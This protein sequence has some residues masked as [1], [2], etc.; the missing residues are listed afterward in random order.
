MR[1]EA[2]EDFQPERQDEV[3]E[4][5][6]GAEEWCCH[7]RKAQCPAPLISVKA[8][9]DKAPELVEPYGRTEH[10]AGNS[11]NLHLQHER[12]RDARQGKGHR[13]ALTLSLF[14]DSFE[15]LAQPREQLDVID[16]ADHHADRDCD[17]RLDEP[18]P[19][20]AEMIGERHGHG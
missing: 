4:E 8:R 6:S 2:E 14:D 11:C 15:R 1:G 20:F 19:Q 13:S 3:G 10:E 5:D 9:G 16:P 18:G 7:G 17:T 12:I